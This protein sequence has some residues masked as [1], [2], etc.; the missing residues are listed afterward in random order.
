MKIQDIFIKSFFY[1]CKRS[2][3]AKISS[4]PQ[5]A[6]LRSPLIAFGVYQVKHAPLAWLRQAAP[7]AAYGRLK[8]R[9]NYH[10]ELAKK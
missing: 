8:C 5:L 6:C 4:R 1:F 10:D 3:V 7:G 9:D 2:K